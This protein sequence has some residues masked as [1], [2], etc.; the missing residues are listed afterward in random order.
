[1]EG[2]RDR[3][4]LQFLSSSDGSPIEIVLF[5]TIH[6][7]YDIVAPFQD[8][9]IGD[10]IVV[11]PLSAQVRQVLNTQRMSAENAN[12]GGGDGGGI[13]ADYVRSLQEVEGHRPR[14]EAEEKLLPR[15]PRVPEYFQCVKVCNLN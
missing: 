7:K 1:M 6:N 11:K 12:E 15:C 2:M 5:P 14:Q 10:D 13:L 8:G 4:A 9:T 3:G